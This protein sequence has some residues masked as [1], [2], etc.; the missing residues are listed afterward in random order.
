MVRPRSIVAHAKV[1]VAAIQLFAEHGI[2]AT[3]MDAI[4]ENSGVSKA[5]IYKH[6]ADKEKLCLEVLSYLHGL[7]QEMPAFDSGDLRDD[8]ITQLKY[9]PAPEKREWR[10]KILPHLMAYAA[11]NRAFGE[12]WRARVMERPRMRLTQILNRGVEQHMLRAD[13]NLE[14]ALALLLGPMLYRRIFV[15]RIGAKLPTDFE[16]QVVDSFLAA[17]IL[18]NKQPQRS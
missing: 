9:E 15:N 17:N 12:Q 6:W 16:S 11:R 13:M 7:D 14:I 1:L 4:A 2:D 8:L 10:E 5:T 3:S 18:T